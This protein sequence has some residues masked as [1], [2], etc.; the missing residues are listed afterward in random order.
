MVTFSACIPLIIMYLCILDFSV[1]GDSLHLLAATVTPSIIND[2]VSTTTSA[3][4][5]FLD[6]LSG[7][8]WSDG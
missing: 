8:R 7:P 2:P 3:S 4:G 1:L 6:L 5:N